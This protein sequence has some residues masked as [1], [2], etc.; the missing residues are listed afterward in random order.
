MHTSSEAARL[1][2][3]RRPKGLAAIRPGDKKGAGP[4]AHAA[5]R[6]ASAIHSAWRPVHPKG[7]SASSPPQR[8]AAIVAA[9]SRRPSR[10]GYPWALS[11]CPYQ[12]D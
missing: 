7:P 2:G 12:L 1:A 6:K 4:G 3:P 5:A 9:P 10:L 11:E 8:S